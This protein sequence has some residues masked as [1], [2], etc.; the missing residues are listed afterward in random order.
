MEPFFIF[1]RLPAKERSPVLGMDGSW[2]GHHPRL[3]AQI[4]NRTFTKSPNSTITR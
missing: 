2:E 1:L 4:N 3:H